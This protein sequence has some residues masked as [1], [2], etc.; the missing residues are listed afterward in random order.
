MTLRVTS[1]LQESSIYLYK[2]QLLFDVGEDLNSGSDL[3]LQFE[4]ILIPLLNLL[5]QIH[6]VDLQLLKVNHV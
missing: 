3:P 2:L 4:N 6:V 1:I 5:I